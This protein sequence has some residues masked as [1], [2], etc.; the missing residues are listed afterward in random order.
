[1]DE[2][3]MVMKEVAYVI[4][5]STA[6]MIEAMGMAAANAQHPQ[7]QPYADSDFLNVIEKY[8]L[9]HNSVMNTLNPQNWG[10]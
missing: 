6:A 3:T 5:Q 4:S 9:Y 2:N 10:R 1:M 8:G 7:D